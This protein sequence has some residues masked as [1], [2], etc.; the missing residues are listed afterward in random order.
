MKKYRASNGLAI[1][2]QQDMRMLAMMSQKGWHLSAM[3]GIFYWFEKGEPCSCQY[4]VN[5]ETSVDDEMLSIYAASGWAPVLVNEEF[6]IFRAEQGASPIFSDAESEIEVLQRSKKPFGVYS[7]IMGFL[8][9]AG[10]GLGFAFDLLIVKLIGTAFLVCFIFVFF[11]YLGL[12]YR[13]WR[14]SKKDT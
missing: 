3:R 6:Q 12:C 10:F 5:F 9:I 1:M 4:A 11:P 2:P 14:R 7:L 8:V 13:I